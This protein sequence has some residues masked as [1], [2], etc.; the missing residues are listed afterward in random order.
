MSGAIRQVERCPM[1]N[2]NSSPSRRLTHGQLAYIT[3]CPAVLDIQ[4][5]REKHIHRSSSLT[6]HVDQLILKDG[7]KRYFESTRE[8]PSR[9]R[10]VGRSRYVVKIVGEKRL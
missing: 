7:G 9:K 3:I 4:N 1:D 5:L 10:D 8:T 6:P 2:S